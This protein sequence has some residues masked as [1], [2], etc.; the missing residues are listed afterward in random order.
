MLYK[1]YAKKTGTSHIKEKKP[2]Q[3][4]LSVAVKENI[5]IGAVADG[6]GSEQHS[7]MA[8]DIAAKVAVRE[9]E[10]KLQPDSND[11]EVLDI[12]KNAFLEAKYDIEEEADKHGFPF[13]ECNTTL[14]LAVYKD[15]CLY[16]GHAGDSGI[17]AL[18]EDGRCV[19][20]TEQQ[21]DDEKRVFPLAYKEN[22]V[23]GKA[24]GTFS[25]L[26]LATDGLLETFFPDILSN[27]SE[28][29]YI[30]HIMRFID[31]DR[32][33]IEEKGYENVQKEA[34]GFIEKIPPDKVDDD[35][36]LVVLLNTD[37]KVTLQPP[38]YYKV[39]DFEALRQKINKQGD[40][41]NLQNQPEAKPDSL[42]TS[43]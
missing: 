10:K 42:T 5:L 35:I 6:L 4:S 30:P 15:G 2:C 7:D 12:I 26:L 40:E 13:N 8:S 11:K 28:P 21:R 1:Y 3:D 24:N 18:C 41:T 34:Q 25:G 17:L 9:C 38:E 33:C 14:S 39:P 20:I 37:I 27:E 43:V 22:W 29:L 16:Y 32:L 23:F 36:A 31:K 19:K